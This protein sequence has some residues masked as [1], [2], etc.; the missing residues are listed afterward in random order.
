MTLIVEDGTGTLASESYATVAF[1]DTY[2]LNRNNTLWAA[3]TVSV[4]EASLRKATDFMGQVYR[5]LWKGFRVLKTQYLDWPRTQVYL[6]NE[7]YEISDPLDKTI[8]PVEI[9]KACVELALKSLSDT[10]LL[11]DTEQQLVKEVIGPIITEY[12]PS[13]NKYK[14]YTAVEQ[15][16][17]PYLNPV[18][19]TIIR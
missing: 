2:H 15:L 17:K 5:N 9:Q 7:V 1:A 6:P 4:K 8:I 13:A 19:L 3:Q 18:A 10:F 14:H 12:Q 11:I 16:L